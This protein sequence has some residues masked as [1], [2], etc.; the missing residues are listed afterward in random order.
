MFNFLVILVIIDNCEFKSLDSLYTQ[1]YNFRWV[2]TM[3]LKEILPWL[4]HVLFSLTCSMLLVVVHK[5]VNLQ[6]LPEF[7]RVISIINICCIFSDKV[8]IHYWAVHQQNVSCSCYT[9]HCW[10]NVGDIF[11]TVAEC[12]PDRSTYIIW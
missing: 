1:L 11:P 2:T 4:L 10:T 7:S 5:Y 3:Y 6:I 9:F 8:S 12:I